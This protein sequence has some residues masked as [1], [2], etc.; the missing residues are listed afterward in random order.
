MANDI[1]GG[2][3]DVG[4]DNVVQI[5][6]QKRGP[7][8]PKKIEAAPQEADLAHH[9]EVIEAKSRFM[10]AD[11]LVA[12]LE[13]REDA[14]EVLHKILIGL[15]R[16][17]AS[18]EFQR[19]ELEKRGRDPAQVSS[20]RIDALKKIAEIE[21]KLRELD[22]EGANLSGEQM[23][24]VFGLWVDKTLEVAREILSPELVDVFTNRL[25][26]NMKNFET[27]VENILR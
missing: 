9:A 21:L 11:A 18:L 13:H 10:S 27:E 15:A 5:T 22:Q 24:R 26:T 20:R 23:Q 14:R 3:A 7:G 1:T 6:A 25:A 12:S 19:I 16:E 17:A 4:L 8:R 2:D